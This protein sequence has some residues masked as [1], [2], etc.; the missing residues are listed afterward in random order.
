MTTLDV[1]E[2]GQGSSAQYTY[3]LRSGG[4]AGSG[5]LE[6]EYVVHVSPTL[7]H[8]W[9]TEIDAVLTAGAA[10]SDGPGGRSEELAR[11]GGLIYNHLFPRVGRSVPDLV[12]RLDHSAGPILVRTNES[13]QG[14]PWELL[15]DGT[16]F[17]GLRR[18]LARGSVGS[19]QAVGG[20]SIDRVRRALVVGDTLGDLEAAREEVRRISGWLKGRGVDCTVFLGEQATVSRVVMHLATEREPYDLF[21]FCGHVSASSGTVGLLMHRRELLSAVELQTLSAAGAPPV[22]FINGCASAGR[23]ESMCRGFMVMGAKTV[24]GT[25]TEVA[26]DGA[27]HFAEEFY[28]RLL[29]GDSSGAAMRGARDQLRERPDMAWASFLLFGDPTAR[30]TEDAPTERTEAED[31]PG[32]ILDRL[33]PDA[34]GLMSRIVRQAAPRGV[35]TSID[36]LLG[37][38]AVEDLREGIEDSIGAERLAILTEVLHTVRDRPQGGAE[39]S[40]ADEN[41][42]DTESAD[43]EVELSDTVAR[44]LFESYALVTARGGTAVTTADIVT[45]FVE[46]GGGASARLLE[47]CGV[48]LDR[49]LPGEA[50]RTVAAPFAVAENGN[51]KLRVEGLSRSAAGALRLARLLA[52][53]QGQPVGS[54]TLLLAF[55]MLGSETLR[56]ALAEQGAAGERAFSQLAGRLVPRRNELTPRVRT[57]LERTHRDASGA[58]GEAAIL[59]ALLADEKSGARA[60]LTSLGVDADRLG[61]DLPATD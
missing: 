25:R 9:C 5:P 59:R 4:G 34:A 41:V 14:V 30:L 53:S 61:Q 46:L 10:D 43:G 35:V 31:V 8:D 32:D 36:L 28:G 15:H 18:D 37:L 48:S 45:T 56:V 3:E 6:T 23:V 20:R 2:I 29:G 49:L 47:L 17:L 54:N 22:V 60:V 40:A 21:H 11:L 55:G 33:A 39:E 44:V 13:A 52:K 1:R 57:M 42:D 7:I 27:W 58:V 26:D 38:L 24:V 16:E 51:G 12:R 50:G 19:Q